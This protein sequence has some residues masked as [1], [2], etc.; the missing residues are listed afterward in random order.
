MAR[1][2]R[3]PCS[4]NW[5]VAGQEDSGRLAVHSDVAALVPPTDLGDQLEQA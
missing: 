4:V 2:W 3:V 1:T 5:C